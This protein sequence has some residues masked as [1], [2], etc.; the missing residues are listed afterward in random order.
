MPSKRSKHDD[1][2]DAELIDEPKPGD[3]IWSRLSKFPFYEVGLVIRK[4]TRYR[5]EGQPEESREWLVV[6]WSSIEGIE[7]NAHLFSR[8]MGNLKDGVSRLQ[9]AKCNL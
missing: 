1:V 4:E 6:E 9:R 5:Y 7:R 8:I 2:L 3:L